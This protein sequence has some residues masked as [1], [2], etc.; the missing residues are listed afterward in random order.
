V[1]QIDE[2]IRKLRLHDDLLLMALVDAEDQLIWVFAIQ[3]QLTGVSDAWTQSTIA[4][5]LAE[6][7]S[8][9]TRFFTWWKVDPL[10][11]SSMLSVSRMVNR[12]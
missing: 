2:G 8:Q 4:E 6:V 11:G 10:H 12:R 3:F 1:A 9:D 5:D 7:G